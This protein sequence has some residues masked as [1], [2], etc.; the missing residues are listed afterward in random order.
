M[1][2]VPLLSASCQK[3]DL[4]SYSQTKLLKGRSVSLPPA[5]ADD[6]ESNQSQLQTQHSLQTNHQCF[7]IQSA[8]LGANFRKSSKITSGLLTTPL[9]TYNET[10]TQQPAS[11][12]DLL[13]LNPAAVSA[14]PSNSTC[15][16]APASPS[17][18]HLY[19]PST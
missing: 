1:V 7:L 11:T 8:L 10:A 17:S 14:Q 4:H 6:I 3:W 9:G 5:K 15:R 13:P 16:P 18:R 19:H 12:T 2:Y